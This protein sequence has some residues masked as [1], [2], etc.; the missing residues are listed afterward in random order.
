MRQRASN[1]LTAKR[2]ERNEK[3]QMRMQWFMVVEHKNCSDNNAGPA[4]KQMNLSHG[5][6]CFTY[7]KWKWQQRCQTKA[8]QWDL[9]VILHHTIC[10][11]ITFVRSHFSVVANFFPRT[12]RTALRTNHFFPNDLLKQERSVMT[13]TKHIGCVCEWQLMDGKKSGSSN[14]SQLN[15]QR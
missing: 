11:Q 6:C 10:A 2:T 1:F 3:L 15:G 13:A 7:E 14:G 9:R 12:E 4:W 5:V 8:T